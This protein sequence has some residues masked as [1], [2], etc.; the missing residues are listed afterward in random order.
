[1]AF[2]QAPPSAPPTFVRGE[3]VTF[4]GHA[5]TVKS[6]D[7]GPLTVASAANFAVRGVVTEKLSDIKRQGRITPVGGA[8]SS[9]QALEIHIFSPSMTNVAVRDLPRDLR[10]GSLMTNAMARRSALRP[11]VARSR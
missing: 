1:V 10:P 8:N 9:R 5:L 6:R 4:D 2:A 11:K 7:G 3:A